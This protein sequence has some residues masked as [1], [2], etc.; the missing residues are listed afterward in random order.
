MLWKLCKFD[1]DSLNNM[2]INHRLLHKLNNFVNDFN[3]LIPS[4]KIFCF[5]YVCFKYISNNEY[6]N[7]LN[8]NIINNLN[9][10][11]EIYNNNLTN[12]N[13]T[14]VLMYINYNSKKIY[15]ENVNVFDKY[16]HELININN[17]SK[18]FNDYKLLIEKY[19]K[20]NSLE[21]VNIFDNSYKGNISVL[22]MYL[23]SPNL[24]N[25]LNHYT[26][27]INCNNNYEL[28]YTNEY[29]G[30]IKWFKNMIF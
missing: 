11:K 12:L 2:K 8:K 25:K 4:F 20:D 1:F 6:K 23:L 19:I 21:T 16:K 18:Y 15:N 27:K 13:I 26:M 3:I 7:L 30:W 10:I 24:I 17:L 29:C 28:I 22:L 9:K 5:K 14:D